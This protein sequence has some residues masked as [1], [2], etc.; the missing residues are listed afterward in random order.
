M[1][2]TRARSL[3]R[4]PGITPST[5]PGNLAQGVGE[6]A[7]HA[8]AAERHDRLAGARRLGGELAGVVEVARVHAAHR[9]P[10]AAQRPL[11]RGRDASGPA[12]AGGWVH[13]QADGVLARTQA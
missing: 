10:V 5:A 9:Q 6:R 2:S 7:D 1:P 8:V 3:P 4:P 13:D 11:D 12:A